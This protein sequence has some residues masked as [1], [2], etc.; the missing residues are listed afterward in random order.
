MTPI[1]TNKEYD[2][3]INMFYNLSYLLG[4]LHQILLIE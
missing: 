2:K 4:V 3:E 1:F